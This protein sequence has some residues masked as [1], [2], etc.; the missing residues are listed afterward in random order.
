VYVR[1]LPEEAPGRG[2]DGHWAP[3]D[4]V[5]VIVALASASSCP[6]YDLLP[7]DVICRT[8]RTYLNKVTPVFTGIVDVI[9]IYCD[10]LISAV[11]TLH[12]V[13]SCNSPF[14]DIL[15]RKNHFELVH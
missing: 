4:E 1:F 9:I 15:W 10:R 12:C 3:M 8:I 2:T 5:A 13:P 14:S 7:D 6:E 11:A